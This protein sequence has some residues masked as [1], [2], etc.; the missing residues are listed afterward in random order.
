M[1]RRSKVGAGKPIEPSQ[2]DLLDVLSEFEAKHRRP[3][4]SMKE[5]AKC[6]RLAQ[7]HALIRENM[8]VVPTKDI[9]TARRVVHGVAELLVA[10]LRLAELLVAKL[11][12]TKARRR[13]SRRG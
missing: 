3:P 6:Y 9:A 1:A 4:V 5:K 7:A 8:G 13:R 11:P 10:K 12:K 2:E